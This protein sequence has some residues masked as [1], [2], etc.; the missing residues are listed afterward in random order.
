MAQVDTGAASS[1]RPPLGTYPLYIIS[2]KRL[3]GQ[4]G[5][6]LEIVGRLTVGDER[7]NVKR[8]LSYPKEGKLPVD[9]PIARLAAV[10]LFGKTE[11]EKGVGFDDEDAR[12]GGATVLATVRHYDNGP[13]S[14]T[15]GKPNWTFETFAPHVAVIDAATA[16]TL[17]AQFRL[18]FADELKTG[19]VEF[20]AAVS[21]LIKDAINTDKLVAEFTPEEASTVKAAIKATAKIRKVNLDAPSSEPVAA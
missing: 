12:F 3:G 11:L 10:V 20:K 7:L 8:W 14:K 4:Y 5:S 13:N 9:H 6:Q 15:P 19:Q 21:E 1:E 17:R 18:L 2:T 16:D